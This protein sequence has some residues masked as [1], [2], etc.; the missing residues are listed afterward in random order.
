[1]K[2]DS[3]I[4]CAYHHPTLILIDKHARKQTCSLFLFVRLYQ[5]RASSTFS[6]KTNQPPAISQQFFFSRNK[7]APAT[8]QTNRLLFSGC[9]LLTEKRIA[10]SLQMCMHALATTKAAPLPLYVQYIGTG[11]AS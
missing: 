8:S 11:L 3:S 2:P 6:L 7:S 9:E 1:L 4:L 10:T 5:P